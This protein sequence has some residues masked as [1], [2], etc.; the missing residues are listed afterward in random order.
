MKAEDTSKLKPAIKRTVMRNRIIVLVTDEAGKLRFSR[1]KDHCNWRYMEGYDRGSKTETRSEHLFPKD[2]TLQTVF[3]DENV[4]RL[5]TYYE[6][7]S[8]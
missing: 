2:D 3:A 7:Q 6:T 1:P 5:N 4:V 8:S